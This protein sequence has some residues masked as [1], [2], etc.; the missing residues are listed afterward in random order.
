[1][2]V[3]KMT[4]IDLFTEIDEI[5]AERANFETGEGVTKYR[6][7]SVSKF[8]QRMF[9]YYAKEGWEFEK[10]Q[11]VSAEQVNG[12]A[13]GKA[14]FAVGKFANA[15]VAN[16]LNTSPNTFSQGGVEVF[17]FKKKLDDTQAKSYFDDEI[18]KLHKN[19]V[20]YV[21][22]DVPDNVSPMF[23]KIL[24]GKKLDHEELKNFFKET[25]GVELGYKSGMLSSSYDFEFEGQERTFNDYETLIQFA[26]NRLKK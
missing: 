2:I 17:V 24:A 21:K 5:K 16:A 19:E 6:D 10:V 22:N 26:V 12:F 4:T 25:L 23:E 15:L 18:E 20:K 14:S 11:I 1:M 8:L 9:N 3:Y 7:A 13:I